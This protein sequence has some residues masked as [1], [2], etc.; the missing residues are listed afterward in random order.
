MATI[1]NIIQS[2][3]LYQQ[4]STAEAAELLNLCKRT[5]EK[6]RRNGTGPKF[7]RISPTCLKYRLKDLIDY[8]EAN[9]AINTIC[10]IR[11]AENKGS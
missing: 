9:L 1:H 7:V 5:L 6:M 8:Q 10:T 4:V 11:E 2:V 3:G